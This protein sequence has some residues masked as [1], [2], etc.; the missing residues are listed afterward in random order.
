MN[1]FL[2]KVARKIINDKYFGPYS[3]V[4]LPNRRSI[5]FL[6]EEIRKMGESTVLLPEIISVNDFIVKHSPLNKFA[7]QIIYF[8]LF[9]IH[10]QITPNDARAVD[11]F[12]QWAPLMLRDF[13]DIDNSLASADEVYSHLNAVKAIQ[14]WNPDGRQLTESQREY[15]AFFN[16]LVDYYHKVNELLLSKNHGY[17][18]MICRHLNAN[19]CTLFNANKNSRFAFAGLNALTIC[20]TEIVKKIKG[21]FTTEF[22]W[23]IDSYYFNNDDKIINDASR[24]IK[25][26]INDLNLEYPKIIDSNL[27]SDHK[28]IEII[29]V[30]KNI[31]QAKYIGNLLYNTDFKSFLSQNTTIVLAD[32]NLLVPLLN[33]LPQS[34]TSGKEINYNITLGY[35]MSDSA[36]ENF[37]NTVLELHNELLIHKKLKSSSI[38]SLITNPFIR[39]SL[40]NRYNKILISITSYNND[41]LPASFLTETINS[42]FQDKMPYFSKFMDFSKGSSPSNSVSRIKEYLMNL[43]SE[44]QYLNKLTKVQIKKLIEISGI[45]NSMLNESESEITFITIKNLYRQLI[46]QSRI[47]L[48]GIPL[49]GV[50]IMGLLETRALDFENV[51]ILS[52]NEG[53]LP[54]KSDIDSFIPLDIRNHFKLSIPKD[55]NEIYSYHFYRLIQKAKNIKFLVNSESGE[56]GGGEKSRFILQIENELAKQNENITLNKS[57]LS[58]K[59]N[60]NLLK[61]NDDLEIPKSENILKILAKLSKTGYSPSALS[62]F[63]SCPLKFYFSYVLRIDSTPIFNTEVEANTF[64][65]VIHN[66][67][68]KLYL[69]FLEKELVSNDLNFKNELIRN[70]IALQFSKETSNNTYK[71][72]RNLLLF[73]TALR[74]ITNF[75]KWDKSRISN[76]KTKLLSLEEKLETIIKTQSG[77]TKF[78]GTLDRIDQLTPFGATQIID[79]KTGAVSSRELTIKISDDIFTNPDYSKAF[80]VMYYAWL[81]SKTKKTNTIESGIISLRNLSNGFIKLHLNEFEKICDYFEIFEQQLIKLIDII[82]ND[83]I[84]FTAT[85]NLDQCQYCNY[86]TICNK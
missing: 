15:L 10:K 9:N 46:H 41:F 42:H 63:I 26:L 57:L 50:Q 27:I 14:Q 68:E 18:G 47:D 71:S 49:S 60:K 38:I 55:S 70:E 65:T 31:G 76:Q 69:P 62:A 73:E 66:T 29:E 61:Q 51:I 58:P 83:N 85:K 37:T 77:E 33:S 39:Q 53:T 20:E 40:G 86:K 24:K 3:T 56:L 45:I 44:S 35:P 23:D 6:R 25:K 19:F 34:T 21:Q 72:G 28:N 81:F 52:S 78:K 1:K 79:Y 13:N 84:S 17:Y 75:L 16:S 2:N 54:V 74:Y 8:D 11:D 12:M 32:E 64:G 36:A 22:L 82:N 80:Q 59:T 43:I 4:V 48:V 5:V 67:L 30:P 7:D